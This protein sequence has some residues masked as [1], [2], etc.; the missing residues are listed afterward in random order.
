MLLDSFFLIKS[1]GERDET[2]LQGVAVKH[3]KAELLVEPGHPIFGGHF[4]ENP[5]VPGVCQI[6][7]ILETLSSVTL[8]KLKLSESDNV[9]FL[10][11]INPLET[12]LLTLDLVVKQPDE[13]HYYVQ[14]SLASGNITFLKFKG[15]L[16][17]E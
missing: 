13:D 6:Q 17:A 10:S 2:N 3:Y 12:P 16:S 8:R 9:K 7:M 1:I 11:M 14:A 15:I 5:I 4:P